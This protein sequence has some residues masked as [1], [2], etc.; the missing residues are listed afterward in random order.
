MNSFSNPKVQILKGL[1]GALALA[2]V[3]VGLPGLLRAQT[4]TVATDKTSY[5]IGADIVVT[6]A[7]GPGHA[8]DWIGIYEADQTPGAGGT[9]SAL[10][11]YVDGTRN[12]LVGKTAGTMTFAGGL[13][14]PGDWVVYLL[15]NDG[16][17]ILAQQAFTVLASP[18]VA[19]SKAAFSPAETI[20]VSFAHGP[21]NPRDWIGIY[22]AGET[23]GAGVDST[24][25]LY[26]DGTK[27][28]TSGL[29]EGTVEFEPLPIGDWV[30]FFLENDG[31][32]VLASQTF[33]VKAEAP[34]LTTDH[35][36]YLPGEDIVALWQ[37]GP[38]NPK[39][40]VGVYP[41]GVVP[42]SQY[43]TLW[44]YVDGTG[45]GTVG[46]REGSVTFAEGLNVAGDW[47]LHLLLDDGYDTLA[48]TTI[49]VVDPYAPFVRPAQRSYVI[50]QTIQV[51]FKNGYATPKDWI[52]IYKAGETPG[53]PAATLYR[54]TDDTLSGTTGLA[55][56]TVAFAAGLAVAGEYVA[57]FLYNDGYDVLASEPFTVTLPPADRA[58]LVRV[59]PSSG[60]VGLPP[61]AAYEA[62]LKQ[63]STRV[64]SSSIVLK[65]DGTTVVPTI[66][67]AGDTVTITYTHTPL[68]AALSTHTFELAFDDNA[69]PANHTVN[70]VQFTIGEYENIVLPAPLY[71]EDFEDTAEGSLPDGWT[72][73]SYT[74]V[75][76]WD[77]DLGNLDSASY[78]DWV[79]VNASRFEDSLI[80]YSQDPTFD[81]QRVL[82][83][84]P[85][86][87]LNG[88]VYNQPLAQGRLLFGNSGYRMGASQVM[89]L[90]T[91]DFNLSGQTDVHLVFHSLWEQNQDSIGAVEYSIDS[92]ATWLPVVYL[93]DADDVLRDG[94]GAIDAVATLTTV[95][96]ED[97]IA[98]YFDPD[99]LEEKGGTYGAFIGAHVTADLAPFISSR[100]DDDPVGSKRIEKFRLPQADNQAKVRIRFAHAGADSWYFGIDNVGLYSIPTGPVEPLNVTVAIQDTTLTLN[101]TGGK[102]PFEV[103]RKADL[104]QAQWQTIATGVTGNTA[105]DAIGAGPAFYRVVGD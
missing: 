65:L 24:Q 70:T 28:G 68:L 101:W 95:P 69:A 84:N 104:G 3:L 27:S 89:Y 52:G 47:D 72:S 93:L 81:Y 26:V 91:P 57:Y 49:R 14:E 62:E 97:D 90:F 33:E 73:K 30:A 55:E 39:D 13:D 8:K 18:T 37:N 19:T 88:Q 80:G 46:V 4:P 6:F 5:A 41:A 32:T 64:V 21:G 20:E 51:D 43:S 102:G 105:T 17:T 86:V 78:A 34:T 67:E 40:W 15:E 61:Q 25:W 92:G 7:D 60:A 82:R 85:M 59:T 53:G 58:R 54:Y 98:R 42:G 76:N 44:F 94:G 48:R 66:T 63:G 74:E 10:W 38:G 16:Y 23:P 45:A 36:S 75:L 77:Y 29:V 11:N 100:I 96:Q 1:R 12:G 71:F 103:Q 50:G 31:Y 22:K 83:V 35:Y 9:A 99:A 2:L 56:G 79:V 87:V